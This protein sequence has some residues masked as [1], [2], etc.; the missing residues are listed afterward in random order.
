MN[1]QPNPANEQLPQALV[2][3]EK[4]SAVGELRRSVRIGSTA[5]Q[6]HQRNRRKYVVD[7][8]EPRYNT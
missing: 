3:I 1:A 7:G 4:L 5:V 2:S 6:L 8:I